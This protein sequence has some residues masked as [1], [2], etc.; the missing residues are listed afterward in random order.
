[1]SIL[2]INGEI[3][4]T[5]G[6]NIHILNDKI[7]VDNETVSDGLSGPVDFKFEGSLESF[8]CDCPLMSHSNIAG[9]FEAGHSK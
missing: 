4:Q 1:L 2:I 3:I 6:K 5:S 8:K 7:L 9:R